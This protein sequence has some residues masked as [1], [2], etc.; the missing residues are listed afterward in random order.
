MDWYLQ[1]AGAIQRLKD[2]VDMHIEQHGIP[3]LEEHWPEED[4]IDRD[5]YLDTIGG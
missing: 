1:N 2:F 4:D 5:Y 3:P